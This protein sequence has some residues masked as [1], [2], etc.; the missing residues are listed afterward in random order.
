MYHHMHVNW[1]GTHPHCL[2]KPLVHTDVCQTYIQTHALSHTSAT[3]DS[4][5]DLPTGAQPLQTYIYQPCSEQELRMSRQHQ[6]DKVPMEWD[7]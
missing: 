2:Q 3:Q 1:K 6:T 7:I 4:S 5:T